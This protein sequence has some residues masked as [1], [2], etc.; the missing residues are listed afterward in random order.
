MLRSVESGYETPSRTRADPHMHNYASTENGSPIAAWAATHR[1]T[2]RRPDPASRPCSNPRCSHTTRT[3]KAAARPTRARLRPPHRRSRLPSSRSGT[4]PDRQG[5]LVP[6]ALVDVGRRREN[7]RTAIGS[8]ILSFIECCMYLIEFFSS[9]GVVEFFW[10]HVRVP[11][12][13]RIGPDRG[14]VASDSRQNA[15]Q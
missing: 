14:S 11:A 15:L 13:T 9:A 5:T 4:S 10:G 6:I 3:G 8:R 2:S 12:P 1:C 7:A